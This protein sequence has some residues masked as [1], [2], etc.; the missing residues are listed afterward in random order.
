MQ[1]YNK[2]DKDLVVYST[3]T[4]V[5]VIHYEKKQK[6]CMVEIPDRYPTFPE[7]IH[8]IIKPTFFFRRLKIREDHYESDLLIM[9]WMNLIKV[10]R[11]NQGQDGRYNIEVIKK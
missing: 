3:A 7:Y 4:R 6:I 1:C 10:C 9:Q 5:R 11:V 8:K 2:D